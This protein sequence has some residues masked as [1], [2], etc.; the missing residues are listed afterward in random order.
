MSENLT[1]MGWTLGSRTV[2]VQALSHLTLLPS[3]A[4]AVISV[5]PALRAVTLPVPSTV[6]T[7]LL[8]EAH[9]TSG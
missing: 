7:S 3:V 5:V 9:F 6:A 4:L 8:D 1:N 2:T